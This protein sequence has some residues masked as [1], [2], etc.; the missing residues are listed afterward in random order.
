M[1]I[2]IEQLHDALDTAR[3]YPLN[4]HQREAVDFG[5]GPLWIIAGPGSGKS[6]VLV[7]RALKLICVDGAEPRSVLM[8]TFTKKAARNLEDRLAAYLLALQTAHPELDSVDLSEM[9]IGTLHSLC[10]DILQEFRYPGY[11]NVRLLEDVEQHM[12][13]YRHAEIVNCTDMVFWSQFQYAIQRF[14]PNYLPNK[15]A[16]AK[17]SVTLFNHI[18]MRLNLRGERRNCLRSGLPSRS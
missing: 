1:I 2:A 18:V 3:G 6:E 5:A 10:N 16:R 4:N 17:A 7:T 11:Q 13:V 14:S 12:F 15:W 8:T 9:R